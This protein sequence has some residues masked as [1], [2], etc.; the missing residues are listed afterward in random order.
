M[1]IKTSYYSFFKYESDIFSVTIQDIASCPE[2]VYLL[3]IHQ[4]YW[5]STWGYDVNK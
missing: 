1:V 3:R 2:L 5:T 4:G